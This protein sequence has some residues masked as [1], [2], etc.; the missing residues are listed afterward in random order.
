MKKKYL[1]FMFVGVFMIVAANANA[2]LLSVS[3]SDPTDDI[4]LGA[5]MNIDII[6][7]NLTFDNSSRDYTIIFEADIQNPFMGTFNLNANLINGDINP[8]TSNP[9]MFHVNKIPSINTPTTSVSYTGTNSNLLSWNN[10][11]HI[12]TNDLP[13]GIPIDASFSAFGSGVQLGGTGID[14]FTPDMVS[15]VRPVPVPG[16]VWLLGSG[17]IIGLGGIKRRKQ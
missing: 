2:A 10:G 8:L 16:A 6:G 14:G 5:P 3:F 7:L 17:L 13:F 4:Y 11:D 12:A 1:V 9:A 15:V